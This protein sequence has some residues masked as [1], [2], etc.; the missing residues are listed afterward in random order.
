MRASQTILVP[1]DGSDCSTRALEYAADRVS[2]GRNGL[3]LV[4]NVQTGMA[5][6]RY[7]SRQMI[8]EHQDRLSGE[9]LKAAHALLKRR[10]LDAAISVH[11]GDPAKTIVALA[12]RRGCEI[13]MGNRGR[14]RV[15]G[16]LLGSVALKVIQ[17][18]PC[19]VTVIK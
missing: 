16:L 3:L 6:S 2:M 15:A 9:A 1:V 4:I 12:K 19:P 10:K 18:A 7:V 14:G 17:L 8:A 13:V 5:P 11:I